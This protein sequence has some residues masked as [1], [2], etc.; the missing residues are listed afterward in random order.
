MVS[1]I[2][3]WCLL[4]CGCLS[5]CD[6]ISQRNLPS[7]VSISKGTCFRYCLVFWCSVCSCCPTDCGFQGHDLEHV[8]MEGQSS[9][10]T[11]SCQMLGSSVRHSMA[12]QMSSEHE[13][14]EGQIHLENVCMEGHSSFRTWSCR[15]LAS[16]GSYSPWQVKFLQTIMTIKVKF[17]WK[18]IAWKVNCFRT[19]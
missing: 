19:L 4:I 3:C 5:F 1:N 14:S 11:W 15:M 9:F 10:R 6:L 12:S 16:S 2:M 13:D 8:R 18:L 17:H 7:L